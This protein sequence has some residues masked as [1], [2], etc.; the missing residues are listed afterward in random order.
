M[1]E[2][3]S[4]L[5]IFFNLPH[6]IQIVQF[7]INKNTPRH[8]SGIWHFHSLHNTTEK[9][10]FKVLLLFLLLNPGYSPTS[11]RPPTSPTSLSYSPPT[12]PS[13]SPPTTPSYSLSSPHYSPS[14]SSITEQQ[15][16]TSTIIVTEMSSTISSPSS[17][18]KTATINKA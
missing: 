14:S 7:A 3:S 1:I 16:D 9:M 15:Q 11:L 13:Y 6:N 18:G 12:T 5:I 8:L 17:R 10:R 2:I 4:K